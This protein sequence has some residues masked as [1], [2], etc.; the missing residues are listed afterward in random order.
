MPASI[1]AN[2]ADHGARVHVEHVVHE[3]AFRRTEWTVLVK[4][5]KAKDVFKELCGGFE[6][7]RSDADVIDAAQA[8]Q[9]LGHVCS[10]QTGDLMA[11]TTGW[12]NPTPT[13][14]SHAVAAR[15]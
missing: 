12:I 7:R 8:R 1:V 13:G 11:R 6:F 4:R 14:F 5:L 3:V 15:E 10:P 2:L 9:T